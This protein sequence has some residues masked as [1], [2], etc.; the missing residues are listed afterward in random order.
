M[1]NTDETIYMKSYSTY[2]AHL[3]HEGTSYCG[4]RK[5]FS[6]KIYLLQYPL[7]DFYK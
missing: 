5:Y 2:L 1:I 6:A 3:R 4:Y 7:E